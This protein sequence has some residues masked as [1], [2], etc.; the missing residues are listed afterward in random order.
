MKWI[1]TANTNLCRIYQF[2]KHGAKVVLLKEI[3]HPE[4]RQKTGDSLTS[5]KPGRYQSDVSMG[6]AYSPHT[7]PKDVAID[8]FSRQVAEELNKG[9]NLNAY[10]DLVIITPDHMNGLL[11]KHLD[12]HVVELI[13]SQI[14]K[15]VM[16]L[17][18]HE[19]VEYFSNL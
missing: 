5:D 1:I 8:Q 7:D 14:H 11:L 18:Q 10:K 17:S 3:N 13:S 9:R 12:K 16:H 2:D 4:N 6:G 15:D 19:L